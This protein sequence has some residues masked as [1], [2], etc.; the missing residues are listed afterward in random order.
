MR[1][2]WILGTDPNFSS[3]QVPNLNDIHAAC[4][5]FYEKYQVVP[6]SVKLTY[7]DY[8]NFL[9]HLFAQ[10]VQTLEKNKKYGLFVM[11]PG[12]MVEIALL[13]SHDEAVGNCINDQS[14]MVVESSEADRA[15]EKIVLNKGRKKK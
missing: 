12:G 9:S 14:V 1:L 10:S 11:V 6:D 7:D 13:N 15:F 3:H 8:T 4:K 2:N 5:A